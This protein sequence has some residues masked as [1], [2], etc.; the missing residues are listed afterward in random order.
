MIIVYE[1][2]WMSGQNVSVVQAKDSEW[3]YSFSQ[4][5]QNISLSQVQT[6]CTQL[7]NKWN[8]DIAEA[9]SHSEVRLLCICRV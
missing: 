7:N 1:N 4:S 2:Q 8:L 9:V 5:E 6:T 3:L